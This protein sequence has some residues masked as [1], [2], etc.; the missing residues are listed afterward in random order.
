MNISA[1][2]ESIRSKYGPWTAHNIKLAKDIYTIS[3]EHQSRAHKRAELYAGLKRTLSNRT[4]R[5]CKV[6]D[7]GCLEGGISIHLAQEGAHCTGIDVRSNHLIKARFASESLDLQRRCTWLEAN[8]T[9]EKIWGQLQKFD[10]IIC[11][12]LLYHLDAMDILPLLQN[13]RK[14][15][16]KDALVIIDSN[17][18]PQPLK[19]FAQKAE[20][21]LWGCEWS[22]HDPNSSASERMA[23]GWSSL[24]NNTAFW[25]TERSLVNALV[26][27]GFGTVVKPLF[28][29]HEWGH[30][31]RDVWVAYPCKPDPCNIPFR[32]DPDPRPWA[33]PSLNNT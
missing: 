31:T 2:L 7:L 20:P 14:A 17:I 28:P 3:A 10:L 12:G 33:H 15:C 5:G 16:K 1:E 21:T 9:T 27:A 11:S 23:A 25:L 24:H 8:V 6:L 13:I 4:L 30:Q 19:S 18:A 32:Q 26:S 29:Y 22:E